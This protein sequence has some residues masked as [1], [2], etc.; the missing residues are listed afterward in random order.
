MNQKTTL[1][2]VKDI[3]HQWY[4]FDAT[5]QILG[6]LST[7][8]ADLLRGKNS[9]DYTPFYDQGN[10]VCI[11]NASK[12][13]VTGNKLHNKIYYK[14]TGYT[15]NLKEMTLEKKLETNPES[16]IYLSVKSMLPKTKLA[17]AQLERLKIYKGAE[18]PHKGQRPKKVELS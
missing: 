14:H 3:K 8:I 9:I 10:Y 12:I 13:K 11:I 17:K 2:K 5:D 7:K 1:P 4:I 6:R 15:G 18:H 16:V